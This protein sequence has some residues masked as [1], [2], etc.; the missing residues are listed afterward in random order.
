[1]WAHNHRSDMKLSSYI[2]H[3]KCDR[4][5]PMKIYSKVSK[6]RLYFDVRAAATRPSADNFIRLSYRVDFWRSAS[7]PHPKPI[8]TQIFAGV[9]NALYYRHIRLIN[10]PVANN[11]ASPPVLLSLYISGPLF[12]RLPTVGCGAVVTP[13][14]EIETNRLVRVLAFLDVLVIAGFH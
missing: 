14:F 9:F 7:P 11:S 2:F 4:Y 10:I 12:C 5:S 1:M 3:S 8:G 6:N 13:R